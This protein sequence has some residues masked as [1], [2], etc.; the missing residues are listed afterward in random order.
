MRELGGG[1]LNCS[2]ALE[3]RM[4]VWGGYLALRRVGVCRL[5][6]LIGDFFFFF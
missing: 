5:Q 4:A 3:E 6:P 1:S 2:G